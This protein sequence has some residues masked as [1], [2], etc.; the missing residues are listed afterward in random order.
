MLRRTVIREMRYL[1]PIRFHLRRTITIKLGVCVLK[2]LQLLL[3]SS[4]S[5]NPE[6]EAANLPT[7][8]A[9]LPTTTA[10]LPAALPTATADSSVQ[11][12][13][14]L[15]NP[16]VWRGI[17]TGQFGY[18]LSPPLESLKT[19]PQRKSRTR[20]ARVIT[21]DEQFAEA[22]LEEERKKGR[23]KFKPGKTTTREPGRQS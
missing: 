18:I 23:C 16:L 8:T 22:E 20:T 1:S 3:L 12:E 14:G 6:T 15:C 2:N 21:S 4:T 11:T 17:V 19:K 5:G 10:A 7:T 9:A 13:L